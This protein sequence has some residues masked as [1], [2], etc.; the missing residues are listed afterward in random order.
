MYCPKCGQQQ[1]TDTTKFCSRCGLPIHGLQEWLARGGVAAVNENSGPILPSPKRVGMRRGAKL[2]FVSVVLFPIFLGLS[3]LV[4]SPVP[5]FVPFTIF[6]AGL[7]FVLYTLIF[8]EDTP[9]AGTLPAQ[10]A[11]LGSAF[12]KNALGPGTNN[13]T[14][15]M[16]RRPVSTSELAQPPSV[17]EHTTKLLVED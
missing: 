14:N 16:G 12:D 6:L 9:R 11:A 1:V 8:G 2:V 3:F 4:D 13:W 5:L 10:P 17:T 7:A 15:T